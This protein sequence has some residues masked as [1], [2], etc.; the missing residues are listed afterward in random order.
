MQFKQHKL[1][2]K[3]AGYR[4][5]PA[6]TL[7]SHDGHMPHGREISLSWLSG[8]I[9]T[10]VTGVL[11]MASALYVSFDGKG[12]F[13]TPYSALS[14]NLVDDGS[15]S[16]DG[17]LVTEKSDRVRPVAA[18]RSDREIIEASIRET[19]N[20]AD[21]IRRQP[22]LRINATLATSATSLSADIPKY[23]PIALLRKNQPIALAEDART[24][25]TDIYGAEV[26]GEVA[27]KEASLNI[28]VAPE[29]AIDDRLAAEYVRTTVEGA[30]S[31]SDSALLA[32]APESVPGLRELSVVSDGFSSVAEN[33][34]IVPKSP[35][36]A[37]E[38]ARTERI[39]SV[40]KTAPIGDVLSK[41]G[42]TER[43]VAAIER[44]MRSVNPSTEV[45]EGFRMRILFGLEPGTET[46]IPYLL[47]L[48][49]AD[50]RH[51][52]TVARTDEGRYVLGAPPPGIELPEEDTEE[53]NV[54][55]L[56]SLYRS[57]YETGRK[58][59]L[60]DATIERIVAMFAYDLDLTKKISPGD[61]IQLLQTEPDENGNK[62][63][64]YIGLELA[65]TER[66]MY[67]FQTEDGVVDFFDENGQTGKKFLMRRPLEGGG[68]LRSNYGYRIHPIFKTRKLHTGVDLAARTGTPIYAGGDGV[69]KRAQW[70]SGYGRYVELNHANGYQTAY[71]H[72]NRIASGMQPGTR[73]RQGQVIGYVG[74]TGY[75]TGPHL[76]YEIKIN[77]RTVDPLS[78]R[79][80]RDKSLP[81]QYRDRFEQTMAQ[82]NDLM[83]REASAPLNV[84]Q[85]TP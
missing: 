78:V 8:T 59:D 28:N 56:P 82:I 60:K 43:M 19:V 16:A 79:L 75:S 57:I 74:S 11:L 37:N 15:S 36:A 51:L 26:E 18:T 23:D 67:R 24:I 40:R 58:L 83:S 47:S 62:E 64:L 52:V 71:A 34:S 13:A 66:H 55:N 10:G 7:N 69:V 30:F 46:Q 6:L 39:I 22:F 17:T 42:F 14:P 31:G 27:V 41:N 61:Q 2:L 5:A 9:L 4:D 45:R 3:S 48:Y 81:N 33:V 12:D 70:V 80:P 76:H 53:I 73:V 68:R 1:L 25:N 35:P 54:A 20:G 21:R 84:A 63:L 77:G 49:N 44:T 29:P 38:T 65:G 32:Y 72:M 50:E 85:A